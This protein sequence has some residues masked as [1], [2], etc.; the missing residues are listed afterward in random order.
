MIKKNIKKLLFVFVVLIIPYCIYSEESIIIENNILKFHDDLYNLEKVDD[1][2][3]IF[4]YKSFLIPLKRWNIYVEKNTNFT[5][6]KY[7]YKWF[8]I[9]TYY[10][11]NNN[12]IEIESIKIGSTEESI[13]AQFGN[14]IRIKIDPELN[15]KY[16][17][18]GDIMFTD[19]YRIISDNIYV[20]ENGYLYALY[21]ND[22]N[23]VNNIEILELI[24][25][26]WIHHP[27]ENYDSKIIFNKD[28]TIECIFYSDPLLVIN[29]TWDIKYNNPIH[30]IEMNSNEH[31]FLNGDITI[32]RI[33]SSS[34]S[35]D[36][37]GWKYFY[38]PISENY[39]TKP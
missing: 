12:L 6:L 11:E 26:D 4:E 20:L 3:N 23:T 24:Q 33:D 28:N 15:R 25:N 1:E 32:N 21:I 5:L 16:L 2:E 31:L 8:E 30:T 34:Y 19:Y 7:D 14:P 9:Y 17:Y 13:I 36:F 37:K 29:G 18:Y 27:S 39:I 10:I 35:F 22:L 38:P